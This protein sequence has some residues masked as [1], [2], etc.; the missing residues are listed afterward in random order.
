MDTKLPPELIMS[1]YE[2]F[3]D[4]RE[5]VTSL[6]VF[7]YLEELA[8]TQYKKQQEEEEERESYKIVGDE[9]YTLG[10]YE[11]IHNNE[12]FKIIKFIT[13][14]E[15]PK[16][17]YYIELLQVTTDLDTLVCLYNYFLKYIHRDYFIFYNRYRDSKFTIL[18]CI[19][20]LNDYLV[21]FLK[22]QFK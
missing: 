13:N 16:K 8:Y 14:N 15:R 4:F 1:I 18:L 9:I 22:K 20:E 17:S 7:P 21:K 10:L 5:T 11:F 12:D 6:E 3:D 19:R 2:T